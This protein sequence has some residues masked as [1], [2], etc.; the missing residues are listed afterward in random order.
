[1]TRMGIATTYNI[2]KLQ[3]WCAYMSGTPLHPLKPAINAFN[4]WRIDFID[5]TLTPAKMYKW[6]LLAIDHNTNW[7]VASATKEQKSKGTKRIFKNTKGK[8][9]LNLGLSSDVK[10]QNRKG[11]QNYWGRV[12]KLAYKQKNR[13]DLYLYQAVWATR[14]RQHSITKISPYFLV[15]GIDPRIPG[16]MLKPI[17]ADKKKDSS[18]MDDN[19]SIRIL[20]A[21]EARTDARLKQNDA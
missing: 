18:N 6:I 4:R 5:Q 7:I 3:C 11:K 20:K 8:A 17:T 1:M 21:N 16:D 12:K 19:T 9:Q 2:M 15:Y 10:R 13:W 14:I